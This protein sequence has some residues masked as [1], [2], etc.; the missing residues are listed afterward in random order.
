[1]STTQS[2]EAKYPVPLGQ[3]CID[4]TQRLK[5]QVEKLE[6]VQANEIAEL[7]A[8]VRKFKKEMLWNFK[9]VKKNL[10]REEFDELFLEQRS[11]RERKNQQKA[12]S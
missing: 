8:E 12:S 10:T 4:P 9:W 3:V 7:K 1:L 2:P 6:S 5:K 11:D